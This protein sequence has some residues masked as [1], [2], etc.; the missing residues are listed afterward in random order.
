MADSDNKEKRGAP[1]ANGQMLMAIDIGNT[2]TVLGIFVD[3]QL[4]DFWRIGSGVGRTGDELSVIV[5]SLCRNYHDSLHESGAFVIGSVV[6][7]L[8]REYEAMVRRLYSAEALTVHHELKTGI[9]IDI[10][11]PGSLGADRIANAAAAMD[12][13]LPAIVVDLGTATTFDVIA[14]GGHYLGGAIAPGIRTSADE[15]F[16]RAAKLPK[17]SIR[18]PDTPIGKTTEESIQS[19]VYFGAVGAIDGTVRQLSKGLSGPVRVMATGGLAPLINEA[20]ETIQ[21]VDEALTLR[22]LAKIWRLNQI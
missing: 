10:P 21:A 2:Q 18:M 11:D 4:V 17:V 8:T 7:M 13:E 12:G 22:G 19:G 6:P 15:L 14:E 20:S 5:E 9:T 16:R 3:H 1:S